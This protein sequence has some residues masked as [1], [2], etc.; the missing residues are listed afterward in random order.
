MRIAVLLLVAACSGAA[1]PRPRPRRASPR[2]PPAGRRPAPNPVVCGSE[3]P[4]AKA[5]HE[6]L[7]AIYDREYGTD[8]RLVRELSLDYAHKVMGPPRVISSG[9]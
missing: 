5:W 9:H 8:A 3:S 6:L 1:S 2:P 7:D 4:P